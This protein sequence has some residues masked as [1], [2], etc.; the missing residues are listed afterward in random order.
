MTVTAT[1]NIE[2]DSPYG[3]LTTIDGMTIQNGARGYRL[4]DGK[5]K[6]D[7]REAPVGVPAHWLKSGDKETP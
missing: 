3:Y 5:I 6:F 7:H 2:L 1:I 4:P